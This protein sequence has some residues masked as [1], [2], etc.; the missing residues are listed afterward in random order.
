MLLPDPSSSTSQDPA[1][2]P[3]I[4]LSTLWKDRRMRLVALALA[5]LAAV[6]LA[7]GVGAGVASAKRAATAAA[8]PDSSALWDLPC[9]IPLGRSMQLRYG[10]PAAGSGA[11]EF[12]LVGALPEHAWMAWGPADP[13]AK[14]RFMVRWGE[15]RCA[16]MR[17]RACMRLR[18]CIECVRVCMWACAR[19]HVRDGTCMCG[20]KRQRAACTPPALCCGHAA[21]QQRHACYRA[22]AAH[23]PRPAGQRRLRR[24]GP[25]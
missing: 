14:S 12:A 8:G 18:V 11:F 4:Q 7:A 5:L 2:K 9:C 1:K 21:W 24:R 25:L 3:C 20:L 15:G 6:G 23:A 13:R 19:A 10:K 17:S 16:R 22:S